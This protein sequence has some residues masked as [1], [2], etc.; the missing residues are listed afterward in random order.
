MPL[1]KDL[2]EIKQMLRTLSTQFPVLESVSFNAFSL[3]LPAQRELIHFPVVPE[4]PFV[5]ESQGTKLEFA[6]DGS[7]V[8]SRNFHIAYS[9][10]KMDLALDM[11]ARTEDAAPLRPA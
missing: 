6:S 5:D 11:L 3:G 7:R 9:G 4:N 1:K 2:K 10:P 8:W